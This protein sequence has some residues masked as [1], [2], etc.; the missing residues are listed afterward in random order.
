MPAFLFESPSFFLFSTLQHPKPN[1]PIYTPYRLSCLLVACAAAKAKAHTVSEGRPLRGGGIRR[2]LMITKLLDASAA[3]PIPLKWG[4]TARSYEVHYFTILSYR[5]PN[6]LMPNFVVFHSPSYGYAL[7]SHQKT[8][9]GGTLY[10]R[11]HPFR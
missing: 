3:P 2:R 5:L 9:F 1:K 11:A 8:I 4:T 7:S 6:P 10:L